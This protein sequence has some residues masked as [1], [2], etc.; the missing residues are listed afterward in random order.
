MLLSA[1]GAATHSVLAASMDKIVV[2]R[3]LEW[4]VWVNV[5]KGKSWA[6]STKICP[7]CSWRLSGPRVLLGSC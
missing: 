4:L 2:K 7:D 1:V 6:R 5:Q 3:I